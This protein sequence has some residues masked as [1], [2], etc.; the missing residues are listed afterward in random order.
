[1]NFIYLCLLGNFGSGKDKIGERILEESMSRPCL[2]VWSRHLTGKTSVR[3]VR[4][5]SRAT[6]ARITRWKPMT[7]HL[8][9]ICFPSGRALAIIISSKGSTRKEINIITISSLY[10]LNLFSW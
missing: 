9:F 5:L 1:M 8:R 2:K 6:T 4:L 7:N 3:P 10:A